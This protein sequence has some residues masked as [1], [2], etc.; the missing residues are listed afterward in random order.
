MDSFLNA[1]A[2]Q[3]AASVSGSELNL[4][5]QTNLNDLSMNLFSID[6]IGKLSQQEQNAY[7]AMDQIVNLS[8]V[9][10]V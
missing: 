7:K 2:Y 8:F 3:R 6:L 1:H 9:N 10:C 5:E 4:P